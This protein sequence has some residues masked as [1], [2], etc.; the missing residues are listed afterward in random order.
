MDPSGES[1]PAP[2]LAASGGGD[3][4]AV[5]LPVFE[6]P[7][8]LLLHLIRINEVDVTDI[9]IALIAEQ[10]VEYVA[11][12]RELDLD[13]DLLSRVGSAQGCRA[14]RCA[15]PLPRSPARRRACSP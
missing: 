3:A 4:Y 6:G 10:Y 12:M 9:P 1:P 15:R 2:D 13:V 14:K 7:L 8:D 11:L 5:K